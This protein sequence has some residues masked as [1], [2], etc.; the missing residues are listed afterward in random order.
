MGSRFKQSVSSILFLLV[1]LISPV[2]SADW[3]MNLREGV[4]DISHT[5]F[6][7]HMFVLWICVG[8]GIVVFGVMAWSIVHHRKSKGHVAAKFHESTAVELVWTIIPLIILVSMAMPAARALIKMEDTSNADVT[9]KITGHQWKW[10]YEYLEDG[11][12]FFSSLDD[13][14]REASQRD[15]GIDP[16]TVEHYL[17]N[18]D[19]P[20]VLPTHK[21]IRFLI[22]SGDVIHAWFMPDFA[23]K[24]DAIPGF[25]NEAWTNIDKE[26]VYR[27]KCA[28]LCGKDHGYM[29]IV[30]VAKNDADYAS[31]VGEQKVAMAAEA[32]SA[33]ETWDMAKLME[34]GG[35]VYNKICAA[36]HQPNGQGLPGVFPALAGS[37]I[38]TG[39][40]AAHTDIVMNGKP[41]TAMQAFASQLSDAEIAAVITFERNSFG[42]TA[43][44]S[45]QPS[46]I[47]ALR[48]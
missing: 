43:G 12:H 1:V 14:S 4:T 44:D 31:W 26:G 27:G 3:T 18:V 38:A 35:Q 42:N 21:K 30:V 33:S 23:I 7:L 8:I 20:L 46:A 41:G 16:D 25:I 19:K 36:C 17:A 39:D 24:K 45:V 32:A 28:E 22:T 5:V 6:G 29:P 2:A 48:K 11:V 13:A 34:K 15:S 40:V 9:I 37:K 47:K 10:E